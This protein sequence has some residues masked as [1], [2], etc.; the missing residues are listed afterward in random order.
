VKAFTFTHERDGS[1]VNPAGSEA[2]LRRL[3]H[4]ARCLRLAINRGFD[5]VTSE[6]LAGPCGTTSASVRKD[7]SIFGEFGIKGS[8]YDTSAL[9][10]EIEEV[11]GISDPPPIVLIGAGR[12]GKAILEGGIPGGSYRITA[13]FDSDPEK[14]GDEIGGLTVAHDSGMSMALDRSDNFIGIIA[15]TPGSAQNAADR[16]VRCGCRSILVLNMEPVTVPDSVCLR[17]TE[18]PTELDLL[19]H[20]LLPERI[21]EKRDPGR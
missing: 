21:S 1:Y 16:L 6:Y 11:L 2:V 3:S 14:V 17:R 19:A 12:I 15:V 20:D 10:R 8:G 5:I 18:I 9:L 13:V 4:Y 7:L